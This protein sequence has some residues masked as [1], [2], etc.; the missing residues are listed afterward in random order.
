[1][2]ILRVRCLKT[3]ASAML[4]TVRRWKDAPEDFE[5]HTVSSLHA[6]P[7]SR[8]RVPAA[9]PHDILILDEPP[10][11][12]SWAAYSCRKRPLRLRAVRKRH[13]T[14][15]GVRNLCAGM[16]ISEMHSA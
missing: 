9:R 15:L 5:G 8:P 14:P 4:H 11:E 3:Y 2:R 7:F 6:Y 13:S 12:C 10:A 16:I 1:M